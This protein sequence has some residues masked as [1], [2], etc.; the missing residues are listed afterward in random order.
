[1][2]ERVTYGRDKGGGGCLNSWMSSLSFRKVIV[3]HNKN[4][5]GMVPK[6]QQDTSVEPSPLPIPPLLKNL[7]LEH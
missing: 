6:Y 7:L 5:L 3:V 2:K 4:G 1:M